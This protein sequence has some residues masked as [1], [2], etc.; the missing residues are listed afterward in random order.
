[1]PAW[2]N[3]QEDVAS[4]FRSLGFEASTNMI[5]EG[6]RGK[7]A[8]DVYVTMAAGGLQTVWVVEC[9]RWKRAVPKERVLVLDGVIKDLGADRGILVAEA[10]YQAGAIRAAEHTNITLTS[11]TDLNDNAEEDLRR[12]QLQRQMTQIG[13]LHRRAARLWAWTQ[14]RTYQP[15]FNVDDLLERTVP[16]FELHTLV[17]PKLAAGSLPITIRLGSCPLSAATPSEVV[18]I[19]DAAISHA[20]AELAVVEVPA[21]DA[22]NRS[23]TLL[24]TLREAGVRL[25]ANGRLLDEGE[26]HAVP[27]VEAMRDI[28]VAASELKA[29]A[30]D[31][32]ATKI[33]ALMRHLIDS[34][35]VVTESTAPDWDVEE[36]ALNS[37]FDALTSALTEAFVDA[38]DQR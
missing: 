19:L 38:P 7:H 31:V 6:A 20:D 12:A 33:V 9:K 5:V 25:L 32:V 37:Q 2:N 14:P 17:L 8:I 23:A 1:M 30:P 28:E 15:S 18:Q 27:F 11:L 4:F 10:G 13:L 34:T 36:V 35:Y 3:Y 22:S 16:T 21:S 29:R 24:A 26:A